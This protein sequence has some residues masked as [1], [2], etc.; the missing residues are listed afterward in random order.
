M[1]HS[2]T[3]SRFVKWAVTLREIATS[4]APIGEINTLRK[5]LSAIKGGRLA[6]AAQP[7]PITT[8]L[9]SDV[10][11]DDPSIIAGGPTV[12]DPST[13]ADALTIA[14]KYRIELP[15]NLRHR[16]RHAAA[17]LPADAFAHCS[18]HIVATAHTALTAAAQ[19]AHAMGIPALVLGD[20]IEGEARE[21]ARVLGGI[22]LACAATHT[23]LAPPCVILS[24]GETGVTLGAHTGRGGRNSEFLLALSQVL[25]G[26]PQISALACDTDGIDGMEDNAGAAIFPDTPLRAAAMAIDVAAQLENHNSYEVFSRLGDLV[27]T[28][29]TRTNANDFR[30]ILIDSKSE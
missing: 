17:S 12:A 23:P 6:L 16:W 5:H 7:T 25:A 10:P 13:A 2:P 27:V 8:L 19:A 4:G 20:R 30:A 18:T 26:H 9:L 29:P 22:A 21:V 1:Q 28:G 3:R 15:A 14:D 11:G 24:G